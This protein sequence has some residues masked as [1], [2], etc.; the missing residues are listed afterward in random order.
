MGF[1]SAPPR[2]RGEFVVFSVAVILLAGASAEWVD[3]R[4]LRVPLLMF[5]GL[6]VLGIVYALVGTQTGV[7]PFLFAVATGVLTWAGAE[8][9]YCVLHAARGGTFE[10]SAGGPQPVQ[11][12]ALIALHAAFLGV[13][14]G[15]AAGLLLQAAGRLGDAA[16]VRTSE[17]A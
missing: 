13:P 4:A 8:T 1:T 6:G 17:T 16:R 5:V 15:A 9:V 7:R 3:L 11:A 12:L 2:R 14:T 10:L